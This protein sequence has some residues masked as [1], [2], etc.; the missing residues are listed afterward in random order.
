MNIKFIHSELQAL[1]IEYVAAVLKKHGHSVE[2]IVDPY[3]PFLSKAGKF[4]KRISGWQ[5][6]LIRKV[7]DGNPDLI[8]FSV[9]SYNL[10]WAYHIAAELKKNSSV[11]IVFGGVQATLVPEVILTQSAADFVI[12]GEGE[13]AMLELLQSFK[14]GQ[15]Y[16]NIANLCYLNEGKI[17]T[18]SLRPLIENL[19]TLPF[20]DKDLV[21]LWLNRGLYRIVT[22]RGCPGR[23]TYCCAPIQADIYKDK[24]DFIR[25]RSPENVIAELKQAKVKYQIKRVLFED[26]LFTYDKNWLRIFSRQYKKEINIP[27]FI[28]ATPKSIDDDIVSF[29]KNMS[30]YSVELGVQS[31]KRDIRE[32][33]LKRY[34][35]NDQ[36]EK[37][38]ILLKGKGINCICDNIVGLPEEQE[39]D[40]ASMVEYYNKLR[41]GKIELLRLEY[42]PKAE[43]I[44][45]SSLSKDELDR[46]NLGE[47]VVSS[48]WHTPKINKMML[49]IGLSYILPKKI[50]SYMLHNQVYNL[51][52]P[53]N[54]YNHINETIFYLG[55]LLKRNRKKVFISFRA[56]VFYKLKYIFTKSFNY[57]HSKVGVRE[58]KQMLESNYVKV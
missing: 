55:A 31:L 18:N 40:L 56:D 7:I 37:T 21:P 29:L 54:D 47:L 25:R 49:L 43:I 26:D 33:F 1:G 50:I 35:T 44:E 14:T 3:F 24:G 42:Y 45:F 30:C 11:P 15:E 13:Y 6:K 22:G 4:L 51:F 58:E 19:D 9:T 57:K 34:Y 38:I 12:L 39:A 36:I 46:I 17:E 41:P 5:Q 27:C 48:R 16:S 20:P 32:K 2:L 10:E 23:C 53:F 52:Y 28:H 8:A